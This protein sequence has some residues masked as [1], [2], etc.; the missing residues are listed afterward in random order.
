VAA[1]LELVLIPGLPLL[2]CVLIAIFALRSPKD[3]AAPGFIISALSISLLLSIRA[4]ARVASLGPQTA[5]GAWLTVGPIHL[6][7]GVL[8]DSLSTVMLIVVCT[9]SL[10]VQIYSMGY[11]RGELGYGRYFAYMSLFSGSMLGLVISSN[12]VQ[13]YIFWELVG[14]CSYLLIGFWYRRPSAAAAAK[15]AFVVTRFGDL[16]FLAA[17]LVLSLQGHAWFG[18]ADLENAVHA[19]MLSSGVITAVALLLFC[20]AAG[21]SAQFPL[22][23]W[24]PDAMEGPT[25]VSALI[26]AATM[27]A[28]GVYLVARTY[29]LFAAAPVALFVVALIGAL[30]L[31]LAAMIAT[32][33]NDIK[34]V[35]AYST[36]SQLGYMMLGLGVGGYTAGVFHLTTHAFFKALLF[37]TAGSVIHSVHSNDMWRMGGLGRR[38]PVTAITCL[39]GALALAGIFPLSGFWSKDE[40]LAATWASSLPGHGIFFLLALVTVAL[41]A[42]YMF[43]L[44]FLT[45]SGAPRSDGAAAAHESPLVMTAPL[46]VLAALAV[47]AG[48]LKARVPGTGAGFGELVHF[49]SQ[50][51]TVEPLVIGSSIAAALVGILVAWAAYRA[52][53]VSPQAFRTRLPVVYDALKNAC[54]FN[55]AWELFAVRVVIAGSALAA[56]FDR[57][58]VNGMVDGVAWLCG[59]ASQR[60]RSLQT[61]QAQLY[62]LVFVLSL[63]VGLVVIL[64]AA[65]PALGALRLSP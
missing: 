61:G 16:G 49:G 59:A 43:R 24:L 25:P 18:F 62:V 56:W 28:A 19:G 5:S 47:F 3:R 35:L 44:W 26:H 21:K 23:I 29:F 6:E 30:T 2:S 51:E 55:H 38:M 34:R 53:L 27:V 22:H 1:P 36:V 7:V 46:V 17:V 15:K 58:V 60:L 20:G 45:F 39:V 12:I 41:T 63:I 48:A 11:M 37:L 32:A 31:F 50:H 57:R 9:V 4:L 65:P 10:L 52:N 13:T 33:E 42:F 64:S 54:Y 14:I 40:I 8:A